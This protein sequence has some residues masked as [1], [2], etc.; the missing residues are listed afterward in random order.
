LDIE[1]LP[2]VVN[3]DLP[4]NSEDYVHRIGRTG[5]A[6]QKGEAISFCTPEDKE[7]VHAIEKL[8]N[9]KLEVSEPIR[10]SRP[11]AAPRQSRIESKKTKEDSFFSKPYVAHSGSSGPAKII[12]E[13]NVSKS[14]RT[15]KKQ[16]IAALF[17][18]PAGEKKD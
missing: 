12:E 10:G 1:Q 8:I 13:K 6:G 16:T 15:E 5:R 14:G 11:S 9:K 18:P 17:M 2:H 4:H 3:Y 7:S